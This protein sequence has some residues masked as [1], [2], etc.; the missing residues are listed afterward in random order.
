MFVLEVRLSVLEV[1]DLMTAEQA[2]VDDRI[3]EVFARLSSEYSS[4]LWRL[5]AGYLSSPADREELYQDIRLAIWEALPRFRGEAS[6]RTW[7]Y[8]IAHNVA[9]SAR[10]RWSKRIRREE[11]IDAGRTGWPEAPTA[12]DPLQNVIE[13]ERRARME[14]A[15]QQLPLVDRQIVLLHLEGLSHAAIDDVVGIGSAA[16]ATRL[17]RARA[18][19]IAAVQAET[20]GQS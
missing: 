4:A 3:R 9:I 16:I 12:E 8:R 6:E 15:I 5:T 11:P 2:G 10:A 18:K 13:A 19:L 20:G 17:S 1:A 14:K 7:L